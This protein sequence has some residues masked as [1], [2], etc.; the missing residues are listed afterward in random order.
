VP[1]SRHRRALAALPLALLAAACTPPA[2]PRNPQGASSAG[3]AD[4]NPLGASYVL[5]PLPSEDDS[6]LGRILP[7][8]PAPGRSLEETARANPCADK[9]SEPRTS[10][11]ANS[12]EDAQELSVHGKARAMLG[13]FGFS[14]DAER[15]THFVYK[16][17]TS[18]R[19]S[20]Q[21]TAEYNACCAAKGCGY[22]YVSALVYGEGEYATGEEASGSAQVD[23]MAVGSAAGGARVKVLHKR[24]VKGWLAAVVTVTDPK[25]GETLGALGVAQ[26]AG[27]TEAGVPET[28]KKLYDREK[29]DVKTTGGGFVFSTDK[30]GPMKENEFVRRYRAVTGATDLDDVETRRNKVSFYTAGALTGASALMGIYGFLTLSRACN[31]SDVNTSS[32][33]SAFVDSDCVPRDARGDFIRSA[34]GGE[35]FDRSRD[36]S[37]TGSVIMAGVG[38]V[39][40]VGFGIWFLL[41]AFKGDGAT[42]DHLLTEHDAVLYANRYNRALLRRTITDVQKTTSEAPR[43]HLAPMLG[44]GSVGLTGRF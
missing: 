18:K 11:T 20:R 31:A 29:L 39:G 16:L 26:A 23:V 2:T 34:S 13:A 22:G 19:V 36:T 5:V 9:L 4:A 3:G 12:F 6:I 25:K 28:V 15:A 8:P 7:E 41:A 42:T 1:V 44:L 32:A 14:G 38:T 30:D 35:I 40:T 17:E 24:K 43:L 10:P 21:D 27:I 33:T 37:N